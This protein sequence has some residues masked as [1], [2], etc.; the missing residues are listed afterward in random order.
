MKIKIIII[1]L[2][3]LGISL[4][5]FLFYKSRMKE[6]KTQV[7]GEEKPIRPWGLEIDEESL[8]DSKKIIDVE[9]IKIDIKGEI[10]LKIKWGDKDNEIGG[11]SEYLGSHGPGMWDGAEPPRILFI[12]KDEEVILEDRERIKI[13]TKN[14]L[15]KKLD[16]DGFYNL[17]GIDKEGNFYLSKSGERKFIK[18][19]KD[20]EILLSFDPIKD[21][22]EEYK[23]REPIDINA[24]SFCVLPNCNFYTIIEISEKMETQIANP[25][26]PTKTIPMWQVYNQFKVTL[27]FDPNRNLIDKYSGYFE[28]PIY[29]LIDKDGF[30]YWTKHIPK[31]K[32]QLL[33]GDKVIN[34][35]E[36]F[37]INNF[38]YKYLDSINIIRGKWI[39]NEIGIDFIEGGGIHINNINGDGIFLL[40]MT[41]WG[42]EKDVLEYLI[43]DPT[44][45]KQFFFTIKSNLS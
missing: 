7:T 42:D 37:S 29:N 2:L 5:I 4:S 20:G 36:K 44:K 21:I 18:A 32:S 45:K 22:I 24:Y 10:L 30:Y 41:R 3:I 12:T 38:E 15:K 11:K 19:S 25:E 9:P 40:S 16:L 34:Q 6:K 27:L 14:G 13:F 1:I 33:F 43:F 26:D 8:K 35:I 17:E 23:L 31:E 39:K 28:V